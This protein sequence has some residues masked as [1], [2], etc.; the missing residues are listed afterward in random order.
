MAGGRSRCISRTPIPRCCSPSAWRSSPPR[1][2]GAGCPR[3]PA[4]RVARFVP[5]RSAPQSL[6]PHGRPRRNPGYPDRILWRMGP[7]VSGNV[8]A[9]LRGDA[10]Y[11]RSAHA[12]RARRDLLRAPVS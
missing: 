3:E 2:P 12:A 5:G 10:D 7:G 11:A 1:R 6:L 4:S 9:V 8:A